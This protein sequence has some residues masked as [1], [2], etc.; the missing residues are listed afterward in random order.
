MNVNEELTIYI[1]VDNGVTNKYNDNP[2][3]IFI[4]KGY[5]IK[6]KVE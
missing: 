5:L 6:T 3:T 2:K 1:L 4:K